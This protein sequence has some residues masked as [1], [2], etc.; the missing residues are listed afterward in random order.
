MLFGAIDEESDEQFQHK[1]GLIIGTGA[2]DTQSAEN[3]IR[4]GGGKL[5]IVGGDYIEW[6]NLQRQ[7]LYTE[8]DAIQRTPKAVAVKSRLQ[9]INSEV[10]I[11]ASIMDVTPKEM[12]QL[13]QGVDLVL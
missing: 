11:D 1:H 6:S 5:T 13:I 3:R 9:E 2:L 12:E 8:N 7:Q 10:T 4:A